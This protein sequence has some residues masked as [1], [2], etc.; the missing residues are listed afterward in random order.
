VLCG[1]RFNNTSE[2]RKE[3]IYMRKVIIASLLMVF[4]LALGS[5]FAGDDENRKD[6]GTMLYLEWLKPHET[7]S[8]APAVKDFGKRGPIVLEARVDIGTALYNE[9]FKKDSVVLV[10]SG[11]SAGGVTREDENTRIWDNLMG[12]P[13]GS[14][15]P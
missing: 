6:V 11:A 15:L 1:N 9:A 5:A 10:M 2:E 3:V 14:D 4:V 8:G 13:G 7:M 12:S